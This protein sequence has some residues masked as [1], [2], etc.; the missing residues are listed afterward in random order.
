M[1][2]HLTIATLDKVLVQENV[3]AVYL[4]TSQ[5]EVGIL[6]NHTTYLSNTLPSQ[7]RYIKADNSTATLEVTRP[8]VFFIKDNQ[9][10]MWLC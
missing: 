6:T 2:F 7:I 1:T 10:R 4:S 9:A 8:G 5:G 3:F